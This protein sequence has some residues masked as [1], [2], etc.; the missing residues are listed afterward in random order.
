MNTVLLNP[1]TCFA[2]FLPSYHDTVFVLILFLNNFVGFAVSIDDQEVLYVNLKKQKTPATLP[3]PVPSPKL[4]S[5]QR[6]KIQS[7]DDNSSH[8]SYGS[9]G[10]RVNEGYS[11]EHTYYNTK[12]ELSKQLPGI[13]IERFS[14]YIKEK[15]NAKNGFKDEFSVRISFWLF[16]SKTIMLSLC[17]QKPHSDDS[18]I[19]MIN[20]SLSIVK[21]KVDQIHK[22]L[23]V[24]KEGWLPLAD[25]RTVQ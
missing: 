24:R 21:C 12:E 14:S 22:M 23:N 2:S 18:V 10:S 3:V 17:L 15:E 25:F 11:D 20:L 8:D 5:F 1:K 16:A 13:P 4:S 6:L 19:K 7:A 9:H